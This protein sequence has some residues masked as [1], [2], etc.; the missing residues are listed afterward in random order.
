LKTI[1]RVLA[2]PAALRNLMSVTL[3]MVALVGSLAF[4]TSAQASA[5]SVAGSDLAAG[6]APSTVAVAVV[7]SGS[8]TSSPAGIA[9]PSKCSASFVAG[10][11]VVL[12][13][14]ASSGWS[15]DRWGGSCSGDVACAVKVSGLAGIAAQFVVTSPTA[16]TSPG[17]GRP[18]NFLLDNAYTGT[19]RNGT[20]GTS[21]AVTITAITETGAAIAGTLSFAS[22]LAGS[23]PFIGTVAGNTV[24]FVMK[25]T[26]GSCPTCT[27]I[28]FTGTA[29]PLGS[30]SGTWVATLKAGQSEDGTWQVGSNWK[31]TNDDL[32]NGIT[33]SMSLVGLSES[34]TGAVSGEV[35]YGGPGSGPIVSGSV[36]GSVVQFTSTP[37]YVYVY[38]AGLSASDAMVG[39]WHN[40]G[41]HGTFQLHRVTATSSR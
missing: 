15:F 7:G 34:P 18:A 3:A 39:T 41:Y 1:T 27:D 35:V 11:N 20:A 32:T 2:C 9:C 17:S 28:A 26:A 23:G 21:A 13:P 4:L 31:G 5:L 10:T 33:V 22:P 30:I 36:H 40:P 37:G 24:K 29:S 16:T 12:T 19:A 6:T 8:V 25:P 14:K 38:T